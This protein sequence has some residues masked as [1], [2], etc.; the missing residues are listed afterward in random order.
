MPVYKLLDEMPY[1][2]LQQWLAFFE[3]RP[4]GW[5]EDNR[6]FKLL[7]AQGVKAKPEQIF[8]SLRSIYNEPS[9]ELKEGQVSAA[10]LKQSGFFAKLQMA[11]GGDALQL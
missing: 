2:E 5:R 1:Y 10:N 8:S 9:E 7:Q 4:V 11:K 6:T 3:A